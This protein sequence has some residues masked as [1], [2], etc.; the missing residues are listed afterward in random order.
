MFEKNKDVEGW[1]AGK[2]IA[3]REACD[4][5]RKRAS[6]GLPL[7]EKKSIGVSLAV[8]SRASSE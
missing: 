7:S 8:T 1:T 4:R 3:Y 6:P 5:D 2:S